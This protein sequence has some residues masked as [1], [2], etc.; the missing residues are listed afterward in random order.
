M[1][2]KIIYTISPLLQ[3]H[4]HA[5]IAKHLI[6]KK[7]WKEIQ[8]FTVVGIPYDWCSSLWHY[9]KENET[10]DVT[11]DTFLQFLDSIEFNLQADIYDRKIDHKK[12]FA[13]RL[14]IGQG[15]KDISKACIA[16]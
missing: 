10:P 8:T 7:I 2:G 5:F 12:L 9:C 4:T 6:G 14:F 3:N 16:I 15:W 13:D 1:N 11:H